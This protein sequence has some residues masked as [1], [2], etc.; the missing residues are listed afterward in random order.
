V[1]LANANRFDQAGKKLLEVA[2]QLT[3][4]LMEMQ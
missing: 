1:Q 4:V 2:A 3:D